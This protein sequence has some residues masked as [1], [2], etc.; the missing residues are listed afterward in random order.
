MAKETISLKLTKAEQTML[1]DTLAVLDPDTAKGKRAATFLYDK[2]NLAGK[3]K[4]TEIYCQVQGGCLSAVYTTDKDAVVELMD[5][6]G[7]H[8]D[9]ATARDAELSKRIGKDLFGRF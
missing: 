8:R 1:L 2:V 5:F 6:D 9:E 3:I 7:D 4:P